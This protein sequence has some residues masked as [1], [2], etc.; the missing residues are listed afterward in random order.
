MILGE[1]ILLY[2]AACSFSLSA[3]FGACAARDY[4]QLRIRD[5]RDDL[6]GRRRARGIEALATS[7]SKGVRRPKELPLAPVAGGLASHE[8]FEPS[9]DAQ[10]TL[11]EGEGDITCALPGA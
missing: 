6:S 5:V 10:E 3:A 2:G 4:V 7:A 11:L 1:G 9:D 8:P